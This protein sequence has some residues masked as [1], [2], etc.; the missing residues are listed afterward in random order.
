MQLLKFRVT[1]F[2]S[3]LDSGWIDVESITALIGTNES[4][5]TNILLPLWK[6]NPADDG[7]INLQDDL[8]RDKYHEYR[9]ADPMPTFITAVFTLEDKEKTHLAN[10]TNFD[11]ENFSTVQVSRDFAGKYLW[12]FPDADE[13]PITSVEELNV[14]FD[15]Y[16][17]SISTQGEVPKAEMQ[18]RGKVTSAINLAKEYLRSEKSLADELTDALKEL[19][20]VE[21]S[22]Q[23]SSSFTKLGEL[24]QLIKEKIEALSTPMLSENTEVKEYLESVMPKYV[25]YSNYG[26]LDSQIYLPQVL[27]N[28]TRDNLGLKE[29][30]KART[31]R[32]LFK[33]VSLDP[34]EI[35]QMGADPQGNP[36]PAEIEKI[37]NK[38]KEREILL[39]S[40]SSAFTKAFNEWWKQGDYTFEFQADGDFFRIW[41]ADKIRPERIELE[42]RSTGLQWF[43][44]FY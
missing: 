21:I 32:T 20:K 18:R 6:L 38:K 29:A 19:D 40:A 15:Q 24:K 10:L 13:K 30:A 11:T 27:Q 4:G 5:K 17:Q 2:R 42:A 44:S 36:S 28:L 34:A 43:F 33:F 14:V 16:I 9:N 8:P 1:E 25:Y 23:S 35:T 37:A 7:A 3:V 31:L 39:S 26:N 41:V 12:A 22:T